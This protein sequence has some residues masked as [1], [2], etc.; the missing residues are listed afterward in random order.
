MQHKTG[1]RDKKG[2][3]EIVGFVVI[4]VIVAVIL[5]ILLGLML[6][7]KDSQVVQSYE[8]ESFLGASLQYTTSCED[9]TG[10][11]SVQELIISCYTG[12]NCIN[13][14]SCQ[15][16]E[17]TV[18]GMIESGWNVNEQSAVKGY[19]FSVLVD[20]EGKILIEEGNKTGNYKGNFADF[21]R[22]GTEYQVVLNVYE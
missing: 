5:V 18:K 15:M 12:E 3:E 1:L 22:R 10:F 20:E 8:V 7:R 19:E 11:L 16:L 4:L 2:Q 6:S 17:S 13:G 21:S 14:N 9:Y